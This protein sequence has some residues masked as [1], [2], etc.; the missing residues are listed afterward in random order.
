MSK[1]TSITGGIGM[2]KQAGQLKKQANAY[3][4]AN[5]KINQQNNKLAQ[6]ALDRSRY[7]VLG[8]QAADLAASGVSGFAAA[9][10]AE[11]TI[12][13]NLADK[14]NQDY[15]SAIQA[16]NINVQ[17]SVAL[18]QANALKSQGYG[19]IGRGIFGAAETA[20]GVGSMN[21]VDSNAA[22]ATQQ[23]NL[24]SNS[25]DTYGPFNTQPSYNWWGRQYSR[26]RSW[27]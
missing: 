4:D 6:A 23:T 10:L 20:A 22:A 21:Y 18:N 5:L 3:A 12:V 13:S 9:D 16:Y 8:A 7:S 27:F 25:G 2:I 19:N 14:Q 24:L 26:V 1:F 17:R 11:N 15:E